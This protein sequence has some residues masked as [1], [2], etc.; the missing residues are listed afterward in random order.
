M[1]L[2]LL[3]PANGGGTL[4][5]YKAA[6]AGFPILSLWEFQ[7]F[8]FKYLENVLMK[9][10]ENLATAAACHYLLLIVLTFCFC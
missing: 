8:K 1:I 4:R 2:M 9:F 7:K 6:R 3:E 5:A 10:G